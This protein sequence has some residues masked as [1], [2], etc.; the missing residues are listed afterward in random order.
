MRLSGKRMRCRQSKLLY[1]NHRLPPWLN[2]DDPR[3]PLE[4]LVRQQLADDI[5]V[6]IHRIGV[7]RFHQKMLAMAQYMRFDWRQ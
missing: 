5:G 2:E 7:A 3:S 1:L 4:P 6:P